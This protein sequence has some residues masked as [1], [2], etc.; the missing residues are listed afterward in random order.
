MVPASSPNL[1]GGVHYQGDAHL[2]PHQFVLALANLAPF[3]TFSESKA[4]AYSLSHALRG[5]MQANGLRV[6]NIFPGPIDDEWHQTVPAPKVAP[7]AVASAIITALKD[8]VEVVYV[9]DVAREI[10]ARWRDNPKAIER[11]GAV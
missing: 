9:G 2:E 10:F 3:G 6:I 4:A 7:S 8:G 1:V 5:E 11:E